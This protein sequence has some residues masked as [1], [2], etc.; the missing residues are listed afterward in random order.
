[1]ESMIWTILEHRSGTNTIIQTSMGLLMMNLSRFAGN[2]N[3]G[4]S[5][6]DE[7]IFDALQYI[8]T[9]YKNGTLAELSAQMKLPAYQLSRILKRH[10]GCNFKELLGKR[11]LQQAAYLLSN[12]TL[13]VETVIAA[14]G[15]DNSSFFYRRF[16]ERYGCSP[17][18]FRRKQDG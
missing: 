7:L 5:G 8:E 18:E 12:T 16:H 2:I 9:H 15:Y 13:P 17:K 4:T 10:T 1:M 6:R 3:R 11:K 14:I